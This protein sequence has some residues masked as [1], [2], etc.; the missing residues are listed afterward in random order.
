MSGQ[1][2]A[3]EVVEASRASFAPIPLSVNLALIKAFS[4]HGIAAACGAVDTLRPAMLAYQGEALGI[5]DQRR[6]VDQI[7]Y[8]HIRGPSRRVAGSRRPLADYHRGPAGTLPRPPPTTPEPNK[9]HSRSR[10]TEK[11]RGRKRPVFRDQEP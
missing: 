8:R 4:D 6:E 11:P 3:G 5:V 10:S 1:H 2:R 7:P 9:S